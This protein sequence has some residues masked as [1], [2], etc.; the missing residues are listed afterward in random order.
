MSPCKRSSIL[1]ICLAT[2][3]AQATIAPQ[4]S[5]PNDPR[6]VL[7]RIEKRLD[8]IT[9]YQ[10]T[11]VTNRGQKDLAYD[12]RGRTRIREMHDNLDV[13]TCIWDGA[14]TIEVHEH[15]QPNGAVVHSTSITPHQHRQIDQPDLPRTYLGA[16]LAGMLGKAL[17]N[18]TEVRIESTEEGYC[19][20]GIGHS[21]ATT[22]TV[23][24][25]KRGYL[26]IRQ[27][28][29]ARGERRRLEEIEFTE[30]DPGIWFP[31]VVWTHYAHDQWL[32]SKNSDPR[33][34]F[35]NVRI[36]D[37]NFDRLLA[38]D[39]PD[40]STVADTVRG[41]RYIVDRRHD[42]T[43][44]GSASSSLDTGQAAQTD[45]SSF[46]AGL[47]VS[48]AVYH[49]DA[50]QALKH[51][52]PPF[53]ST[54]R[55]LIIDGDADQAH[56]SEAALLN[57]IYVFQCDDTAK[58]KVC[59]T[60]TGFLR[61]SEILQY[62]CGL[63]IVEYSGPED[64]LELRLGGD[65]IVRRDAS[66]AERLRS[67]ERILYEET[68]KNITFKKQR[69]DTPVVKAT[70]IFQYHRP[71]GA[72]SENDVQLFAEASSN[73]SH[74]YTGGG[75]GTLAQFLRH[76]TNRTGRRFVDETLSSDMDVSW[77]DYTSSKLNPLSSVR[78]KYRY[79]LAL[80]LE[81][82]TKQTGLTFARERRKIDEWHLHE[83]PLESGS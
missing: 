56:V 58:P 71:P 53:P 68:G 62:V 59:Y 4:D 83:K 34:R 29:F 3:L 5:V 47:A 49:L 2:A 48:E 60:S 8:A 19:R 1:L 35:T 45:E 78:E 70:G 72:L 50:N 77:S 28:L 41:V 23:L 31:T 32:R 33:L 51:I 9:N 6:F 52:A 82:V 21:Q 75:S 12:S 39:L 55:R 79:D 15:L 7:E 65:W 43:I 27:D 57:A 13:T 24:D 67:L 63:D 18:G 10:C 26:P 25:P 11:L 42:L 74:A 30:V 61:L 69:I 80:L 17:E 36:N 76:L 54:R 44:A 46:D 38:P 64:L 22:V 14:R 81:N 40:G 16:H 66:K 20:L 73:Q 37:P